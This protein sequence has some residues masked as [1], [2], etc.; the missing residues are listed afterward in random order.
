MRSRPRG[1]S[2]PGDRRCGLVE[3]GQQC[4]G[5]LVEG[6]SLLREFQ[7]PR[8]ALEQAQI[9]R[10]FQ[11]GDPAREGGLWAPGGACGLSEATV[12]GDE[13]EIGECEQVH[14]STSETVCLDISPAGPNVDH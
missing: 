8:S 3:F 13:I 10:R 4:P 9:E 6:A 11:F 2:P 5:P 14:R 12:S 7:D 1:R